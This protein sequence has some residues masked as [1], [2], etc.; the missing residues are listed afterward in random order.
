MTKNQKKKFDV[1]LCHNSQDKPKVIEIGRKL[2]EQGLKP[3]LESMGIAARTAL[4][5]RT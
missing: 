1:F 5:A 3:W 4:A 2:Q